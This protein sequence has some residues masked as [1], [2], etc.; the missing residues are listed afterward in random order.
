MICKLCGQ[1][2]VSGAFIWKSDGRIARGQKCKSCVKR[3]V[4]DTPH[5]KE[6]QRDRNYKR[7]HGIS[8]ATYRRMLE[9]QDNACAICKCKSDATG[10]NARLHI[11]HDHKTG[12]VRGL[13]CYRC[14]IAMGFLDDNPDRIYKIL[15]YL[16]KHS[17]V[18]EEVK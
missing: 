7:V 5:F 1:D 18:L 17:L 2:K 6:G 16:G 15:D 12:K 14:N 13:L 10:K 8:L 9:E 11:D 3:L 4:Y